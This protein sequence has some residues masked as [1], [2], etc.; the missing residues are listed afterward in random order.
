MSSTSISP[1][2]KE[3]ISDIRVDLRALTIDSY[4]PAKYLHHKL[5]DTAKLFMK[6]EGDNMRFQMYPSI[7]VTINDLEMEEVP[8]VGCT[9]IAIPHCNTVM[10]SKLR[11]PDIYT[12]RFG[13]LIDINTLDYN[14]FAVWT[15]ISPREYKTTKTRR[16]QDPSKRYFWIYN[17]YLIIPD[18]KIQSVTLRAVFCD[19][20]QGLRLEACGEPTCILT[21]DQEFTVPG[22]LLDDVKNATVQKIMGSRDRIPPNEYPNLNENKKNS[23]VSEK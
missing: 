20:A 7:W 12:T 14:T 2:V 9:D 8:L 3:V 11:L 18:S 23:P 21:M 1:P 15:Q 4:I 10:K 5:L 17:G 6:R 16:Y 19:K 13:Y 22:H